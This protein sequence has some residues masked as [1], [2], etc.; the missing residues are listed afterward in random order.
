L[1]G[2]PTVVQV[3]DISSIA[4]LLRQQS[5][6]TTL[7]IEYSNGEPRI[8]LIFTDRPIEETVKLVFAMEQTSKALVEQAYVHMGVWK[9][10]IG[11]EA[12]KCDRD[13]NMA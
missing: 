1:A 12:Q 5:N 13:I 2:E 7:E 10:P 11:Q 6:K 9:K 3:V 8:T 4:D